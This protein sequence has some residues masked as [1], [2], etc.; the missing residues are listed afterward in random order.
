MDRF[1]L[2]IVIVA[3]LSVLTYE[4]FQPAAPPPPR[5]VP[6]PQAPEPR[7]PQVRLASLANWK[8]TAVDGTPVDLA[9][10][11]GKVVLI[12]F[13]ATWCPYCRDEMPDLVAAYERFHPK[14]LEVIGVSLDQDKNA[15]LSYTQGNGMEWPEYFDGGNNRIARPNGITGIPTMWLIGRDGALLYTDTRNDLFGEIQKALA[16]P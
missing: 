6:P 11:R 4:A 13:W 12:D 1:V 5:N 3:G 14:G 2:S 15:L 10:M 9:Q 7:P 8:F 16:K